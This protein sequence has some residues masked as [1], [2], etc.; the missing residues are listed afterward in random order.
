MKKKVYLGHSIL[1][2]IMSE[3][4][5]DYIDMMRILG[6][7]RS[8]LFR[9]TKNL[10]S[11]NKYTK[12]LREFVDRIFE[13]DRVKHKCPDVETFVNL[14]YENEKKEISSRIAKLQYQHNKLKNQLEASIEQFNQ[15]VQAFHHI[16]FI[17][18][19]PGSLPSLEVNLL[20]EKLWFFED[21]F[22]I[23]SPIHHRRLELKIKVIEL[24]LDGLNKLLNES[25]EVVEDVKNNA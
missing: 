16:D 7:S 10:P 13:S 3:L 2:V 1:S 17:M 6:V 9:M 25:P 8:N 19:N 22:K 21:Q 20:Q 11:N 23:N 24:E 15:Q 14:S 18:K 4:A 12:I 5:L